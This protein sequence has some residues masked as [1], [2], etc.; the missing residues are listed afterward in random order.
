MT[1]RNDVVVKAEWESLPS[2]EAL[3]SVYD[4]LLDQGIAIKGNEHRENVNE[5][6]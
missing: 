5:T 1:K 2:D 4:Y 3:F 6:Q